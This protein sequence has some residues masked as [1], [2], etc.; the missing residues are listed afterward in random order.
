MDE[1]DDPKTMKR[2]NVGVSSIDCNYRAG[3]NSKCLI[4]RVNV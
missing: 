1:I 2:Q 4:K 3:N